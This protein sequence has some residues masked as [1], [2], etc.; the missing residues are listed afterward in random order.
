MALR[1]L[2]DDRLAAAGLI[3]L[4]AITGFVFAVAPRLFVREADRALRDELPAT[5]AAVRNLQLIQERR[6]GQASGD[7]LGAVDQSG[8]DLEPQIPPAVRGRIVGRTYT[9]DT[10][11]WRTTGPTTPSLVTMRFQQGIADRI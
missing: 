2:R 3:A 1:R 8:A 11:R 10:P 4:V 6:I 5:P 7:P 9:A